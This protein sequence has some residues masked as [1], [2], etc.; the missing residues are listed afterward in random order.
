MFSL[1]P[2]SHAAYFHWGKVLLRETLDLAWLCCVPFRITCSKNGLVWM[3]RSAP[4]CSR[5]VIRRQCLW[6]LHFV[7]LRPNPCAY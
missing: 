7:M 1:H 3:G 2:S 4:G 5:N 6:A